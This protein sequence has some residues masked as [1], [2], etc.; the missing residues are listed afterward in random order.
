MSELHFGDRV[1]LIR[2]TDILPIVRTVTG[3]FC[4]IWWQPSY[5]RYVRHPIYVGW[6]TIFWA[7]PTMTFTRLIFAVVTTAYILVAIQLEE[8]DL[9]DEHGKSYA[10]YRNHVPMLIPAL[11]ARSLPEDGGAE[12]QPA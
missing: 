4:V 2:S 6:V 12:A 11:K 7:A 3:W 5:D 10:D 1:G 9:I 8:R